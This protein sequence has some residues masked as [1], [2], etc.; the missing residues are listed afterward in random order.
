[1]DPIADKILLIGMVSIF[2]INGYIPSYVFFVL[3][4][5]DAVILIGA[6][7]HMTVYEVDS[8]KPNLLGKITTFMQIIYFLSILVEIVFTL[9]LMQPIYHLLICTLCLFSLISYTMNWLRQTNE[10]HSNES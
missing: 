9:N 2:W 4:F 5:R 3:V 6:A 10:L 8:P 7:F 1:M